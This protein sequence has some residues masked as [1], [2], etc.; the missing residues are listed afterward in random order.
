[1]L[2]GAPVTKVLEKLQA[3]IGQQAMQIATLQAMVEDLTER[4]SKLE[5]AGQSGNGGERPA[6][7]GEA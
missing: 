5:Q 1:M 4:L 2:N 7:G 3:I 6:E